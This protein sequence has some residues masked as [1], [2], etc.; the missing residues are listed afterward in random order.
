VDGQV[1]DALGAAIAAL[2][3]RPPLAPLE[4]RL[5]GLQADASDIAH[6]LLTA[7]DDVVDDPERLEALR[8]RRQLFRDLGRKYG[9][10]LAEVIAFRAEA[11]GRLEALHGRD[12]RA[13][14]LDSA[15]ETARIRRDR[16]A[17]ELRA[18]RTAAAEP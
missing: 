11:V 18:A 9:A 12:Q 2:G 17:G 1:V 8:V 7:H 15:R 6:E 10:D 13:A 4:T 14:A 3:G 16:L 5:R